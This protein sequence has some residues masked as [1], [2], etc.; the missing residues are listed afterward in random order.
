MRELGISAW[1]SGELEG[2]LSIFVETWKED[3]KKLVLI[4]SVVPSARTGCTNWNIHSVLTSGNP[5]C[6]GDWAME[7]SLEYPSLEILQSLWTWLWAACFRWPCW[8]RGF[9]PEVPSNLDQSVI[10]CCVGLQFENIVNFVLSICIIL[11]S[12]Q[13]VIFWVEFFFSPLY[14]E[15]MLLSARPLSKSIS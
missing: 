3:A 9:G 12:H 14:Y 1:R 10:L 13:E 5:Y 7:L 2:I 6:A 8:T 15:S 11:H 4:S